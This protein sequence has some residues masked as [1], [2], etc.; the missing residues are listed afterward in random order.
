MS[1]ANLQNRTIF[2]HDNLEVLQGINSNSIDLIYLDPPFNSNRTYTAPIGSSAE[3]AGFKDIWKD[4]DVKIE[5]LY[6][7]KEDNEKLFSFLDSIKNIEGEKIKSKSTSNF[8]YLAYMAIRLIEM[9]R[10]L[11]NTG[12]IYLHCDPTMSHYI[13]I[14]MDIIFGEK[15][16]RNEIAWCYSGGGIPKKD[17]PRK[18]DIIFR[19]SKT[20]DYIFNIEYRPYGEHNKT[21]KRATDLNGKR[22][23]EYREEGTPFNDWWIDI[24]PIINWSGQKTGYP[25]QKPLDLLER[26]IKA[27]SNEGD[28]VLDPFC[29][30]A[31]TCVASENL[32]RQWIGIDVSV[33]AYDLVRKRLDKEVKK[34]SQTGQTSL[35]DWDKVIHYHTNPPKRTDLNGDDNII[36]KNV[37]IISHPNYKKADLYKVGIANDLNSRLNSYQTSDPLREYKIE[38]YKKTQFYRETENYI[39]KKFEFS[40]EWVNGKLEDIIKAIEE[41]DINKY[42]Q[43]EGILF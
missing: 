40:H 30:C 11:Q 29:G 37:Y 31:T 39:H 28:L 26:I 3:G 8:C 19:Y 22:K 25:T 7:I 17:Y 38:F 15:N 23:V 14:L 33:K 35:T 6:T 5:W 9:K 24:K 10:I 2:C 27:S 20:N 18:K 32:N 36:K 21:G 42:N 12:S 13:K 4:E 1:E 34:E 16:F 43:T 41:F